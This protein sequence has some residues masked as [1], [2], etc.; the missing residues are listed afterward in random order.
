MEMFVP[1]SVAVEQPLKPGAAA[2][3][4]ANA[5][6]LDGI[7]LRYRTWSLTAWNQMSAPVPS[8]GG[9]VPVSRSSANVCS[10]R[11][12]ACR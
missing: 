8:P 4:T 9:S 11:T 12:V 10:S 5:A 3:Y 6:P 1:V 2:P 7:G